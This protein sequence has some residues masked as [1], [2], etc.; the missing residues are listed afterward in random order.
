V[1]EGIFAVRVDQHVHIEQDHSIHCGLQRCGIIQ[2]NARHQN[3]R[4]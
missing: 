3:R 4:P 2:I 1:I